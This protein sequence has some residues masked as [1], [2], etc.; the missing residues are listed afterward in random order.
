MTHKVCP[1]VPKKALKYDAKVIYNKKLLHGNE[2]NDDCKDYNPSESDMGNGESFRAVKKRN[3]S[4]DDSTD[5]DDSL[6]GDS[7]SEDERRHTKCQEEV[8]V[9]PESSVVMKLEEEDVEREGNTK[10]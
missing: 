4:K 10:I 7:T 6:S 1:E 2:A 5:V 3:T 8:G 9:I